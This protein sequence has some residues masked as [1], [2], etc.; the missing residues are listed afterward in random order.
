MMQSQ[1]FRCENEGPFTTQ[2]G[3]LR[4]K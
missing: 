2:P 1:I 3:G 4:E